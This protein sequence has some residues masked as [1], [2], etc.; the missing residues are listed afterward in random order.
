M[1]YIVLTC[2]PVMSR[3]HL[4]IVVTKCRILSIALSL[5][6]IFTNVLKAYWHGVLLAATDD[7]LC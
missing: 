3:P 2:L 4:V 5:R 1:F 6:S 7:L